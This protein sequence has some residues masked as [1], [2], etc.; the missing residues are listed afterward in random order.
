MT[1]CT[2]CVG[3][4]DRRRKIIVTC[5]PEDFKLVDATISKIPFDKCEGTVLITYE[6]PKRVKEK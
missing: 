2:Q 1:N 3:R 4:K 5:E 6:P